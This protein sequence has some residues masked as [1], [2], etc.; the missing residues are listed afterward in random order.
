MGALDPHDSTN[1]V[2]VATFPAQP[3]TTN[4]VTPITKYW[5][6]WGT[7]TPGQIIDVATIATPAEVDFTGKA[8]SLAKVV[9]N[10]DG[11]WDVTYNS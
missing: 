10:N 2:P 1:I 4:I 5:I 8:A 7:F 11:T 3:G 9:H 6:S